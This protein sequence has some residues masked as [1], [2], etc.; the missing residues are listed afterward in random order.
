MKYIAEHAPTH[1]IFLIFSYIFFQD[2]EQVRY[3]LIANAPILV[4]I[5]FVISGFL[6]IHNYS[7]NEK[8]NKQIQSNSVWGNLK[9]L[10]KLVGKR[11]LR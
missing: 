10:L 11:Y 8:Q 9:L 5:F 4:D 7:Q 1:L 3:Q 2:A 6:L